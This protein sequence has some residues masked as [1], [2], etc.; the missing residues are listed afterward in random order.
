MDFKLNTIYK[1]AFFAT[2]LLPNFFNKIGRG[3]IAISITYKVLSLLFPSTF[4]SMPSISGLTLVWI[5]LAGLT[6]NSISRKKIEDERILTA[7]ENGF[8]LFF[9]TLI[10]LLI[11]T[12]FMWMFKNIAFDAQL[13]KSI[14]F[15]LFLRL[16][17]YWSVL[18]GNAA[19]PKEE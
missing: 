6:I 3:L 13:L 18:F 14:M 17:V 16:C 19:P 4:V 15:S 7:R 12:C 5:V 1:P 9:A 10:A 8:I 11:T 2:L